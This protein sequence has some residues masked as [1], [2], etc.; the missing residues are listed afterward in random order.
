MKEAIK[1]ILYSLVYRKLIF[2][3]ELADIPLWRVCNR[4]I[5]LYMF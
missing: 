5:T 2:M 3:P 4:I 1:G